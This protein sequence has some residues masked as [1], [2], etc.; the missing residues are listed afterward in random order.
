MLPLSAAVLD[1]Y[2]AGESFRE[3]PAVVEALAAEG[4]DTTVDH[5]TATPQDE[6]QAIAAVQAYRML[7]DRIGDAGLGDR[8]EVS[9]DPVAIGLLLPEGEK[10]AVENARKICRAAH[11]AGTS[12]TLAMRDHTTVDATLAVAQALRHDFPATGITLQARLHRTESDCRALAYAGSRVRI[13][14]GEEDAPAEVAFTDP[15]DVD[16]SYVRCMKVLLGG[17][18]YPMLATHD[19][20]LI[21]IA[22][23]LASRYGRAPGTYEYQAAPRRAARRAAP[24]GRRR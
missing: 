2:V 3:A 6:T 15:G 13:C 19:P 24:P 1:R 5:L 22:G 9:V 21:E 23:A 10:L 18:G 12:L 4:I 16:R 11:S 7:L 20:R 8:A 17:D 14:K